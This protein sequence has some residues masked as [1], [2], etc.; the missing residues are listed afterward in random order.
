MATYVYDDFRVT[1]APRA[2]GSFDVRATDHA[3]AQASGVFTTPLGDDEL[4]RAILR[5]ARSNSRKAGRDDA[6]VVSRDI[7]SD[8]P[9]ALDAEQ[10]GTLLGSALLSAGSATVTSVPGWRPRP[11]GAVCA[12]HSRS[13]MPR[14]F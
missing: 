6:P 5:V 8:E 7:G 10:I 2:D 9:P 3:G 14:R 4:Q 12:C 13:P 11:T 1:F